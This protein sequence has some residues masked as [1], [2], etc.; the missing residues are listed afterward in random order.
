MEHSKEFDAACDEYTAFVATLTQEQIAATDANVDMASYKKQ[1]HKGF[2]ASDAIAHARRMLTDLTEELA[3]LQQEQERDLRGATIP[4][5][6]A[7]Y[8]KLNDNWR[9]WTRGRVG[10]GENEE[11]GHKTADTDF[12]MLIGTCQCELANKD[13]DKE[14]IE[15]T[16]KFEA[17][18]KEAESA[19]Q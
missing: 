4:K 18:I 1:F 3:E 2:P 11:T 7:R 16:L 12:F 9:A 13:K 5:L 6:L 14:L 17:A 19:Q 8:E 15:F 10:L